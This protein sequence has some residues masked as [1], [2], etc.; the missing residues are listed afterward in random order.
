V[1]NTVHHRGPVARGLFFGMEVSLRVPE[2]WHRVPQQVRKGQVHHRGGVLRGL[3]LSDEAT[4]QEIK[5]PG[6]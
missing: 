6:F 1:E 5:S 3:P 2:L 4:N